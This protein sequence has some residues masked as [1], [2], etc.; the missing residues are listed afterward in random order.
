[1]VGITLTHAVGRTDGDDV[2]IEY[3]TSCEAADSFDTASSNLLCVNMI[4][5][6]IEC[7]IEYQYM[8][9]KYHCTLP[10]CTV[11]TTVKA[12]CQYCGRV[13]VLDS[14]PHCHYIMN[15]ITQ[16]HQTSSG[17]QVMKTK[18]GWACSTYGKDE[19]CIRGS[20]G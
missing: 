1:M 3:A 14:N 11:A 12:M 8:L 2:G 20:V 19:W 13:T 5:Q 17:N 9:R 15:L 4:V 18:M 7:N 16:V 6:H 10:I